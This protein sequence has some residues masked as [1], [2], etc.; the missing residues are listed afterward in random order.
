[1]PNL[2]QH[3]KMKGIADAFLRDGQL[4][5][6]LIEYISETMTRESEVRVAEREMI[7]AHVSRINGCSFCVG[8]HY[9]TLRSMGIEE[10]AIKQLARGDRSGFSPRLDSALRF[11]EQL[12]RNPQ[13]VSADQL[14]T[15]Q[16]E[17]WSEQA[18][19]DIVNVV[20]LFAAVNRLVDA[21]GFVGD[22][23]YF[24]KVGAMLSEDGYRHLASRARQR[25]KT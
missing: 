5:S 16:R 12:T 23:A 20:A 14:H 25:V 6:P 8:V 13:H 21:F 11:A 18:I 22:S 15:L 2:P 9:D 4:Y 17:G 3:N 24:R 10:S 19:E 1:M 7:A